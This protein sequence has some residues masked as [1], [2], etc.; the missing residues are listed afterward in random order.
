MRV[1][2]ILA[3][4]FGLAALATPAFAGGGGGCIGCYRH[5]VTPPVYGTVA[6]TVM[7]RAPRTV[8]H[9]IPG[10]Y[11]T[12]AEKVLVAP[13]R[14]VW[15]VTRDAYGQL[16]GCW[17]VVP[18]RY[19]V[20]HRTVMVRAPQLVH[21]TIPPV[22]AT[23]HREV[24]VRPA[25]AGWQPIG[26][27]GGYGFGH[28]GRIGHGGYGYGYGHGYGHGHVGY[29]GGAIGALAATI[30]GIAAGPVGALA[31]GAAADV[32]TDSLGY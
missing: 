23:R 8:A 28:T 27:H 11:E 10:A 26:A 4:A 29:G 18:A 17:V 6:E 12:V 3:S 13:P 2:S 1:R 21:E 16:V 15:Q 32:A 20:R 19:A 7:V 30:G 24:L 14:K 22:Y 25:S 9:T 5:V 31:A